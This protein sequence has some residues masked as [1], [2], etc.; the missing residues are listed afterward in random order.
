MRE[1][2]GLVVVGIAVAGQESMAAA[3]QKAFP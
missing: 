1:R 3:V 2:R